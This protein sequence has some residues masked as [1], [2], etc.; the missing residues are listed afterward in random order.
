MLLRGDNAVGYKNYPEWVIRDFIRLSTQTGLD[1][2]RVFDC[3]NN[4]DKMKIAI[5]EIK[6][7]GAVAEACV[8]YTGNVASPKET[9][10]N[11]KILSRTR[12]RSEEDG[13]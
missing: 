9:K 10:Y 11:L 13:S 8:C 2:F 1:I 4:P 5:D 12:P 7:R 3:L 6:K